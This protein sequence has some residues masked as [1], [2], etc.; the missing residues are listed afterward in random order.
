MSRSWPTGPRR[1]EV[2]PAPTGNS[3]AVAD[4]D[5]IHEKARDGAADLD[6]AIARADILADLADLDREI[7]L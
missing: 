7:R 4:P 1:A 3:L 2:P 6:T 5:R